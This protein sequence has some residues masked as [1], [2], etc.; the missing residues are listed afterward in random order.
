MHPLAAFSYCLNSVLLNSFLILFD[1]LDVFE[2]CNVL[3]FFNPVI[4]KSRAAVCF[5]ESSYCFLLTT[6]SVDI[7]RFHYS[8]SGCS[9]VFLKVVDVFELLE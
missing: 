5:T 4:K 3:K 7:V 2:I 1:W 8:L 9:S 6:C